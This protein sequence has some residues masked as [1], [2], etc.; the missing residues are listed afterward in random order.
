MVAIDVRPVTAD[1]WNALSQVQKEFLYEYADG[2]TFTEKCDLAAANWRATTPERRTKGLEMFAD[3]VK[4]RDA[5][6]RTTAPAARRKGAKEPVDAVTSHLTSRRADGVEPEKPEWVWTNWLPLSSLGLIVGRQG[7]SKTTFASWVIAQVTTGRP[8]PDDPARRDPV[9]A[10]FLSLEEPAERLVARLD[11]AGAD[12]SRIHI[13]GDVEDTDDEGRPFR[14]PW[15]LPADCTVLED[16]L[17]AH[18]IRLVVVDGLGYSLVGDSHNYGAVG[19][20]LS[21]LAGVA[22]RT[23]ASI[24]GLTHPPKGGSDPVTAAIGSTAWTAVARVVWVLGVDP[25]DETGARRVVRVSKTNFKEPD[26]GLSFVISDDVRFECGYVT[27]LLT[28]TVT[29]E[30]LVAASTPADERTAREEARDVLKALLGNDR[31]I[32]TSELLKQTRAAG[33]SD[34]SVKRARKDLQVVARPLH[35]AVTKRMIGWMLSLPQ[36]HGTTGSPQGQTTAFDPLDPLDPL[37]STRGI[38]NPSV[39]QGPQGP[40]EQRHLWVNR[41]T[42]DYARPDRRGRDPESSPVRPGRHRPGIRR[43]VRCAADLD[44]L[45]LFLRSAGLLAHRCRSARGGRS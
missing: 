34:T 21:S 31:E 41:W 20:A 5:T 2:K 36:D 18:D 19:A 12:L 45:A 33:V 13:L 35:D 3:Q 43:C 1:P 27:G 14:R 15:R 22:E 37:A 9:N 4:R 42:S 32:E 23:R 29:A 10:A 7:G 30:D 11:A 24:L 17:I 25:E 8:F 16:F 44:V 40:Q 38:Y 26:A 39:P 6:E 28:S